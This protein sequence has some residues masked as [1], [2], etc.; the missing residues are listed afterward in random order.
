MQFACGLTKHNDL[1]AHGLIYNAFMWRLKRENIN[2]KPFGQLMGIR[3]MFTISQKKHF[4]SP[5]GWYYERAREHN[6]ILDFLSTPRP[7]SLFQMISLFMF[8]INLFLLK[9]Y[10]HRTITFVHNLF[11]IE[12]H[13]SPWSH[14]SDSM[15]I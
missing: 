7:L 6:F 12:K 1:C 8:S 3:N 11:F 15:E 10:S 14:M 5:S 4:I 2:E 9:V 13:S